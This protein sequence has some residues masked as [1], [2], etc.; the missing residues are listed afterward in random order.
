[1]CGHVL[2]VRGE[3]IFPEEGVLGV[4]RD[5]LDEVLLVRRRVKCLRQMVNS[6]STLPR[7][8]VSTYRTRETH[9]TYG[10]QGLLLV[11]IIAGLLK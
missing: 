7:R 1:M 10:L 9:V 8:R 4:S 6:D 3:E 2:D 11:C 5:R